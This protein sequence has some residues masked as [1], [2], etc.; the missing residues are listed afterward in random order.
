MMKWFCLTA[1]LAVAVSLA[2]AQ[3]FPG[4]Q[5]P[6]RLF[7]GWCGEQNRI[8]AVF[9]AQCGNK[10]ERQALVERLTAKLALAEARGEAVTMMPDEVRVL[11]QAEAEKRTRMF[12][13]KHFQAMPTKSQTEVDRVLGILAPAVIGAAVLYFG[14]IVA[15]AVLK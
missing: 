15:G 11:A 1:L 13:R 8:A 6:E 12:A 14:S 2:P 5:T 4:A 3:N 9:C 7:C 10:L